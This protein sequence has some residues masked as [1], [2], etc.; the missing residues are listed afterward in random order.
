[1]VNPGQKNVLME[2]FMRKILL[3]STALV[4][5]AGVSAA[6]AD[7]HIT[8]S[9]GTDVS[10]T[11]VSDDQTDDASAGENGYQHYLRESP[12]NY[13]EFINALKGELLQF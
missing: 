9:G 3:A 12:K 4:A 5:V 1:M 7:G 13:Y 6:S 2:I 10:Y 8:F 11:S